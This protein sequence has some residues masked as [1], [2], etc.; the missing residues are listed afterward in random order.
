MRLPS[1]CSLCLAA[2]LMAAPGD[3]KL[4]GQPHPGKD[5]T[6]VTEIVT[7]ARDAQVAL[8]RVSTVDGRVRELERRI[9]RLE[10]ELSNAR[11]LLL[12][13]VL[14]GLIWFTA[15][16]LRPLAREWF[17]TP[18]SAEW[19]R[20]SA[21]PLPAQRPISTPVRPPVKAKS[22]PAPEPLAAAHRS[23]EPV[24][25]T[26]PEAAAALRPGETIRTL[27]QAFNECLDKPDNQ[28][29]FYARFKDRQ[30]FGCVNADARTKNPD[31]AAQFRTMP[32]GSCWAF[33]FGPHWYAVPKLDVSMN[34]YFYG[35]PGGL[36][37][38][39]ECKNL[40]TQNLGR[41][42]ELAEAARIRPVDGSWEIADKGKFTF[43]R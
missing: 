10:G 13:M 27:I 33:K 18:E 26:A 28:Y 36:H 30:E 19:E 25:E 20:S 21:L 5:K 24:A 38:V 37:T 11:W 9:E 4:P 32:S 7:A 42:I 16:L 17:L 2:A 41:R 31:I 3:P 35:G 23:P 14:A 8:D 29:E 15:S 39:F 40:S 1:A 34:D 43:V 22:T 12:V 6:E